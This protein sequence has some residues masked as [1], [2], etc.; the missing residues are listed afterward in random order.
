MYHKQLYKKDNWRKPSDAPRIGNSPLIFSS[1]EL[2][3]ITSRAL[4]LTSTFVVWAAC[5]Y[6]L[7]PMKILIMWFLTALLGYTE[8]S[9]NDVYIETVQ[10]IKL[11]ALIILSIGMLMLTKLLFNIIAEKYLQQWPYLSARNE[12]RRNKQNV[13]ST[14]GGELAVRA[15][16]EAEANFKYMRAHH[17]DSGHLI[18]IDDL[19]SL[20]P[21]PLSLLPP[22][23]TS[24]QPATTLLSNTPLPSSQ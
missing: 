15:C 19:G 4:W 14:N 6:L 10:E 20:R 22:A 12:K 1:P 9:A 2:Q 16:F 23:T 5:L 24:L 11:Y 3:N 18:Y 21:S 7:A 13:S 8:L 17:D